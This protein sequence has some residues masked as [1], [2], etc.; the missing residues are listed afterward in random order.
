MFQFIGA[1]VVYGLAIYGLAKALTERS[2][3]K[4]A[5]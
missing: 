3:G 4:D 1:I 5:R 2:P